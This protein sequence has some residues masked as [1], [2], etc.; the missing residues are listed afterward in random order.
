MVFFYKYRKGNAIAAFVVSCDRTKILNI[1]L[2]HDPLMERYCIEKSEPLPP[3]LEELTRATHE[4]TT[5][6][7]ML[8]GALQ[9]SFLRFLVRLT[10]ARNIVEVGTFTGYSAICMALGLPADGKLVSLESDERMKSFHNTFFPKAGVS[11]KIEV[12]YGDARTTLPGLSGPFDM[13]FIDADKKGYLQYYETLLPKMRPGGLMVADNVLWSGRVY[14]KD[15]EKN[16]LALREFN[17][18][19]S[20]DPRVEPFLLYL[21]DGLMLLRV[22][23]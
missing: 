1:M 7:R 10:G 18:R 2:D 16:T 12:V 23:G 5:Q 20:S 9:G 21:R 6:P 8:S 15:D 22:K 13:A 11:D 4:E 14:Q 19:V 3:V 17:E